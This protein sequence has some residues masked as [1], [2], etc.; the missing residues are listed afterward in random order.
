MQETK[1]VGTSVILMYQLYIPRNNAV[2]QKGEIG[3]FFFF[4]SG[5]SCFLN[6]HL[7]LAI[8][9]FPLDLIVGFQNLH[10]GK[11]CKSLKL[12][13]QERPSTNW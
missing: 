11:C 7:N 13:F 4:N 10:S 6:L 2:I 12:T 3:I 5:E 8:V 9:H 1:A